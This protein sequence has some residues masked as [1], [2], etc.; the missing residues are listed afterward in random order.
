[1]P[2]PPGEERA[3]AD[4]VIRYLRD[5]GLAVDED[6]TG[7]KIGSTMGNIF[8]SLEPTAPGQPIFLCAHLD[9]VPAT[10]AIEPVVSD[11]MVRNAAGGRGEQGVT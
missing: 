9:T 7:P 10:A 6:D 2:S 4:R 11:G 8:V 5:C 3:V 1:M